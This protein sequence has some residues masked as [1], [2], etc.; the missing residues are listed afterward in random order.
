MA[1]LTKS[2]RWRD[3]IDKPKQRGM[4]M[5]HLLLV[6]CFLVISTTV[7][8]FKIVADPVT[9]QNVARLFVPAIDDPDVLES[10][11]GAMIENALVQHGWDPVEASTAA[12][13]FRGVSEFN[14][15]YAQALRPE[16]RGDTVCIASVPDDFVSTMVLFLGRQ[17]NAKERQALTEWVF[18]HET[19][20]C[21]EHRTPADDESV[22]RWLSES[23][24]D[25]FAI[26]NARS[27]GEVGRLVIETVMRMRTVKMF[28]DGYSVYWTLP[29]VQ[30]AAVGDDAGA[31]RALRHAASHAGKQ[32]DLKAI[33]DAG[34]AYRRILF[35]L[36]VAD[37]GP[38]IEVAWQQATKKLP[39]HY[40]AFA[41]SLAE[42]RAFFLLTRPEQKS[43]RKAI[44]QVD[45]LP[46]VPMA[47]PQGNPSVVG[48]VHPPALHP[49]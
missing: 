3:G 14:G 1:D 47:E 39:K 32:G 6:F 26:R 43:W 27:K 9:T 35:S 29:F 18:D 38:Q 36:N 23:R 40:Q 28:S 49:E 16:D 10:T 31:E 44:F 2:R 21:L 48:V 8:A 24:A 7:H 11:Y 34:R 15:A 4:S 5:Y 46:K 33:E 42:L 13:M 37:D 17:P 22:E 12:Y 20:H 19:A 45:V 25:L 41:P 30:L